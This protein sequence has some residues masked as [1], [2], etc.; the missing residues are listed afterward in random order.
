QQFCWC[1]RVY[2]PEALATVFTA[3]PSLTLSARCRVMP[4]QELFRIKQR[5]LH[6]FPSFALVS[7]LCDVL[8]RG[9]FFVGGGGTRQSG[10]VKTGEDLGIG[11]LLGQEFAKVVVR[12]AH[13][14]VDG[15]SVDQLEGLGKVAVPFALALAGQLTSGLAK[16]LQEEV[17]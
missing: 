14:V 11:R 16:G 15:R 4:G 9:L 2:E 13:L 10:Q 7:S 1:V 8:E 17:V 6:V 3:F 5:P 12:V